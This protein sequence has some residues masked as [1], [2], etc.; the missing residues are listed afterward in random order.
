MAWPRQPSS[1]SPQRDNRRNGVARQNLRSPS[2]RAAVNNNNVNNRITL[3][4]A[5]GGLNEP[6][7]IKTRN[8]SQQRWRV[9]H[10]VATPALIFAHTLALIDARGVV[11][12]SHNDAAQRVNAL[13]RGGKRSAREQHGGE[14]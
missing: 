3:F 14:S 1:A 13:K 11:T 10:N 12:T 7:I 4:A 2:A 6:S 8:A 9:F 5:L